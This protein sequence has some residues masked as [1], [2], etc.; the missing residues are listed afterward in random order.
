MHHAVVEWR[1]TLILEMDRRLSPAELEDL[2]GGSSGRNVLAVTKRKDPSTTLVSVSANA[3]SS[4]STDAVAA[5]VE[6][7]SGDLAG[8]AIPPAIRRVRHYLAAGLSAL[9][10]LSTAA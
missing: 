1:V 8:L 7:L 9:P 10:A 3:T 6:R 5:S 4:E 2:S